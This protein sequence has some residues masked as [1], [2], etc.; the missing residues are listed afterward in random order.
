MSPCHALIL[1]DGDLEAVVSQF[2]PVEWRTA[3]HGSDPETAFL[4]LGAL[5]WL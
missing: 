5:A 1:L 4:D 2:R 3:Y